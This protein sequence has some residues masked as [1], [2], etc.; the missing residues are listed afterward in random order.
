M[1]KE[2]MTDKTIKIYVEGGCVTDVISL[3]N[4]YD[5]VIIDSDVQEEE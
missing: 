4:G 3:P 5:Y 2:K 1:E